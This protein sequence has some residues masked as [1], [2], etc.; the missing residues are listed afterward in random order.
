MSKQRAPGVK[1][2]ART[3]ARKSGMPATELQRERLLIG[4]QNLLTP[5][6]G[7]LKSELR[8]QERE[9]R[10]AQT[11]KVRRPKKKQSESEKLREECTETGYTVGEAAA[12]I[13]EILEEYTKRHLMSMEPWVL[14]ELLRA[15]HKIMPAGAPKS[16]IRGLLGYFTRTSCTKTWMKLANILK[17][18][19]DC[20]GKTTFARV[21]EVPF[22]RIV[23]ETTILQMSA[24]PRYQDRVELIDAKIERL[25]GPV[26]AKKVNPT[27]RQE[28][29]EEHSSTE[30][31]PDS[32]CLFSHQNN[33]FR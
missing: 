1:K 27:N 26:R 10:K 3:A 23:D 15:A 21:K 20:E 33:P 30:G 19:A 24:N 2:L 28:S 4:S 8:R 31:P 17:V 29:G 7:T 12:Q 5:G 25:K 6:K 11:K 14:R 22:D 9:S 16:K 18:L 32:P 13:L